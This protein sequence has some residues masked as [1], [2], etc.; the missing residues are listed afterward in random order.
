MHEI[1]GTLLR[2]IRQNAGL[3]QRELADIIGVRQQTVCDYE[4]GR[5]EIPHQRQQQVI[6]ALNVSNEEINFYRKN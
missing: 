3:Y 4:N 2:H 5:Y 6:S 1:D